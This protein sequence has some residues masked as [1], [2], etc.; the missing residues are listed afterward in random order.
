MYL[1]EY[2]SPF[3]NSISIFK[4]SKY[5]TFLTFLLT[6]MFKFYAIFNNK[7]PY[8]Y[9]DILSAPESYLIPKGFDDYSKWHYLGDF[10][11]R[12]RGIFSKG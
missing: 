7:F 6:L 4:G 8:P 11:K 2:I 9:K 3:S 10:E 5:V 12:L 1:Q